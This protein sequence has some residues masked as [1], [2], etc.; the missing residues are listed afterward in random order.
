VPATSSYLRMRVSPDISIGLGLRVKV[1][2]ERMVGQDVELNLK[3]HAASEMPPYER[4]LGDAMRGN[5]ELFARQD[6]VEAQWRVVQPILDNVTPVYEYDLSTWG[7][8]EAR[9][10][11][12]AD[13]P[14]IDPKVTKAKK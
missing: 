12:G 7:P 1:P 3:S 2:G 10:L 14:W 5:G 8:D 4:L 9:Q 11:I 6:L 13:G